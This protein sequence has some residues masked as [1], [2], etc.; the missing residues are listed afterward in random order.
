[1]YYT[2]LLLSTKDGNW[3]TG[4]TDDLKK[5]LLAHNSGKVES[6][7]SRTP[8]KLIYYESCNNMLDARARERFL[9]SGQGKAYLKKRLKFFLLEN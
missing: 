3:Y 2:Y 4:Y 8:L 1:M 5:R 6:T 7:K 9:K